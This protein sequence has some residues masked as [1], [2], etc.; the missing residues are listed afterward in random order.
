MA[1]T[2]IVWDELMRDHAVDVTLDPDT[3]HACLVLSEDRKQVRGGGEKRN[4]PDNPKR[5]DP[6]YFVLGKEGFSKSFYYEVEVKGQMT[7]EVGVVSESI[8][9]KGISSSF[10]PANG[11][12]TV[13]LNHGRYE[14]KS[15]PPVILHLTQEPQKVGVFVDYEGQKV[16]FYNVE[17]RALIHSFTGCM[18][19]GSAPSLEG[20]PGSRLHPILRPSSSYVEYCSAPLTITPV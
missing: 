5:F 9:R 12:W 7:W 3:A 8:N 11:C 14:D 15:D 4:L 16:S 13:S 20:V 18:F 10:R 2:N 19:T 1:V 17:T 6:C